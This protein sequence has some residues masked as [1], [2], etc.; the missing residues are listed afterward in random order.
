MEIGGRKSQIEQL[1]NDL[2]EQI[3][4]N[5]DKPNERASKLERFIPKIRE[6]EAA[7]GI[8]RMDTALRAPIGP[9]AEDQ[10][11]QRRHSL[12]STLG[13]PLV[14]KHSNVHF[15]HLSGSPGAPIK[16]NKTFLSKYSGQGGQGVPPA[17][18]Y[19]KTAQAETQIGA[20]DPNIPDDQNQK[21][22]RTSRS[23]KSKKKDLTTNQLNNIYIGGKH[24]Q[25]T[26]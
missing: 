1:Q 22:R 13:T 15:D 24:R 19:S 4:Q 8:R 18:E 25:H 16:R 17:Q 12:M 10:G 5:I 6:N 7:A 26:Q 23:N 20:L 21:M 11:Q 2:E 14:G 9:T 3:K